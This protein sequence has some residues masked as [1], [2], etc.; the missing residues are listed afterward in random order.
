MLLELRVD[1]YAP[2][3]R[4]QPPPLAWQPDSIL[5]FQPEEVT[6]LAVV[7]EQNNSCATLGCN[8]VLYQ[9]DESLQRLPARQLHEM[10]CSA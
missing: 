6:S 7:R 5:A 8:A 10:I 2:G 4:V 9:A 3:A 1:P